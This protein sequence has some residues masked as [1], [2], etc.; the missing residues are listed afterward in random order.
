MKV[1]C[2]NGFCELSKEE[3]VQLAALLLKAGYTVRL[4]RERTGNTS[5]YVYIINAER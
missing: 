1:Y 5:K 4:E 2:E 3:R